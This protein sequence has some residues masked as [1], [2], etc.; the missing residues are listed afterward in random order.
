[1]RTPSN[2]HESKMHIEMRLSMHIA[3]YMPFFGDFGAHMHSTYAIFDIVLN[4]PHD[5][6]L[7][8]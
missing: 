4:V 2:G 3:H 6:A 1:M 7:S 5:S 8:T